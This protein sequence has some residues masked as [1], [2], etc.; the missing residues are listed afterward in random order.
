MALIEDGKIPDSLGQYS[1]R[2]QALYKQPSS[3]P[4]R[5][6]NSNNSPLSDEV[7]CMLVEYLNNSTE[8]ECIWIRPDHWAAL[9]KSDLIAYAPVPARGQFYKRYK[10]K[11]GLV[12]TFTDNPDNSIIY[13]KNADGTNN[14]FGRVF[15]IFSHL[16]APA[17]SKKTTDI[18]IHVQSFPLLPRE[19]SNPFDSDDNVELKCALRM[20]GPTENKLI[21]L[22]DIIAQCSWIM[23]KAGEMKKNVDIPTIGMIILDR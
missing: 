8:E 3:R 6:S 13:F 18:W 4:K 17:Q 15:S 22:N 10:Y 7:L 21:K 2:I 12:S 9:D 23:Y 5:L 11:D 16:R 14:L 19:H 20:W 1:S